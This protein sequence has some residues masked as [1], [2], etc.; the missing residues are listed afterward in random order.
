MNKPH[1]HQKLINAW[2]A[3][4]RIEVYND[5]GWVFQASPNW[6]PA[7]EYRLAEIHVHYRLALMSAA[8]KG[9]YI[10]AVPDGGRAKA[11]EEHTSFIE[12]IG[13]WQT[14]SVQR[15]GATITTEV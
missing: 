11:T 4:A 9:Y 15:R 7:N 13:D 8:G 14:H 5:H 2:A 1:V 10:A 3:G 12:W 6:S